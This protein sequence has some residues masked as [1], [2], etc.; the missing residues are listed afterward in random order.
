M[1]NLI[2]L[3][4]VCGLGGLG[5]WVFAQ[6]TPN[7][8]RRPLDL[9]SGVSGEEED[10]EDEPETVT[11]YGGDYEGDG[12]FW[13]LD[14]SCSM[15]GAP[16]VTLKEEA[17]SAIMQLSGR[18]DFGIV[19]FNHTHSVFSPVP[20]KATLASKASAQNWVQSMTADGQTC[21]GPPGVSTLNIAN[22]SSKRHVQ[23]VILG[24]G[25]PVCGSETAATVISDITAANYKS[26]PIHCLFIGTGSGG[27]SLFQQLAAQNGGTFRQ[28][29]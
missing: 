20:T 9:P 23:V 27:V 4:L 22:Q 17:T 18:A 26:L 10:E 3:T 11:F 13:C 29:L 14:R 12:F 8:Q 6:E 2:L 24:D 19:Q 28:I 5:T 7:G 16:I 15:T 25:V 21:I 1:R